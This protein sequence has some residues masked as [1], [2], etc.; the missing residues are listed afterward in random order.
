MTLVIDSSAALYELVSPDG[1]EGLADA[2]ELVA[3]AL[4]WSEVVSVL[5]ETRWRGELSDSLAE[6]ALDRL[7][8]GA[9]SRRAHWQLYAEATVL[10]DRLGWARTYDAEFVAL[11]RLESAPLYTRDARL[12]RRVASLVDVVGPDDVARSNR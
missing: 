9:I 7:R 3:P 2:N 8:H 12:A 11:A 10:A 1:L 4:L 5:N 6:I